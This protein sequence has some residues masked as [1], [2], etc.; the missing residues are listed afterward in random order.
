MKAV[1]YFL[2]VK[3]GPIV[4]LTQAHTMPLNNQSWINECFLF[5]DSFDFDL[6]GDLSVDLNQEMT[7]PEVTVILVH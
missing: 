5:L 6:Y 4:L 7:Y 3:N 1:S 2:L